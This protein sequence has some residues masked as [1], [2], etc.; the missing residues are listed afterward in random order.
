MIIL[1]SYC[2]ERAE[3][4]PQSPRGPPCPAYSQLLPHV[5]YS[6][7]HREPWITPDLAERLH[8]Y[9]GGIIRAER[10]V[11]YDIGGVADHVHLYLRWRPDESISNL[12]RTVKARSS[13]WIHDTFPAL[14]KFAWQEGY[15]RFS[16]SQSQEA[17]VKAYIAGQAEHHGKEDRRNCSASSARMESSSTS[18][19]CLI[20]RPRVRTLPPP[21][22][23]GLQ[24]PTS[25]PRVPRRRAAP[26]RRSTRGYIPS[27]RWGENSHEPIPKRR[28]VRASR[29]FVPG[30]RGVGIAS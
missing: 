11:L 5:V 22:R 13:G 15:S 4:A 1:P 27:P 30:I 26:R 18:A 8:P 9:L 21:L 12:M 16:V 25:C 2:P 3:E 24:K 20:E 14:G 23:G 17:A 29:P 28:V 7:K 6:T 19:T 10:G